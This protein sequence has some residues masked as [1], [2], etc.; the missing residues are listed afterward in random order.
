MKQRLAILWI[1]VI[2]FASA[3]I[4]SGKQQ[5][6]Y[7]NHYTTQHGLP[8]N[9]VYN[10]VQDK[11]GFI[12]VSTRDGIARFDGNN[13][14]KMEMDEDETVL[15]GGSTTMC[16]DEDGAIWF[17]SKNRVCSYDPCTGVTKTIGEFGAMRA[18]S[19]TSDSKGNIWFVAGTL[20][21]YTKET[22]ELKAYPREEY[23]VPSSIVPDASGTLWAV[24]SDGSVY[25]YDS[26]TDHFEETPL[27]DVRRLESTASGK[28]MACTSEDEILVIEPH[29]F[30]IKTILTE[31]ET[32]GWRNILCM[33]ER[34]PGEYWIGTETGI[35]VYV[36][37]RGI[38][39]VI[40]EN[41]LDKHAI[42]ASYV[43]KMFAD[44]DGNIWAGTYYTG[45]NL[46]Q[47]KKDAFQFYYDY[48]DEN[49]LTGNIVRPIKSDGDDVIWFGTED[50]ELNRYNIISHDTQTFDTKDLFYNIQDILPDKGE[51]W[52][53]TYGN[54]LLKYNPETKQITARYMLG[55]GYVIRVFKTSGN[56]ILAG[57]RNGLYRYDEASGKFE[58][59]SSVKPHFIHA[60]FQDHNG[61][62]WIGTLGDGIRV[63]DKDFNLI[64]EIDA[65][66]ENGLSSSHITSI[67]EDSKNRIWTTT[68]GAGVF[69]TSPNTTIEGIKFMNLSKEDGL[70]S[71]VTCSV[72][73][74][75]DGL[76]WISTTR[77]IA[78]FNPETSS[79]TTTF[80]GKSQITG[81]QYTFDSSIITR[82]GTIYMGTTGGMVS[83]SPSI[84]NSIIPD[85]QLF[86]FV[87]RFYMA[88]PVA[89]IGKELGCS[90]STVKREI[91]AIKNGLKKRLESE[92][93]TV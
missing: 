16:I 52:V 36:E 58:P 53:A 39:Y 27:P 30:E 3:G 26:R 20:Y 34:V 83:F 37:G 41:L 81:G 92:G 77:G 74:D 38:T 32:E 11:L 10:I 33:A 82:S 46:W 7:F 51:I 18:N 79:L 72:E 17:C 31:K 86:I 67:F 88:E 89:A 2:M 62:I 23:P 63:M 69:Y 73:E 4:A 64:A 40:Q 60:L 24:T 56:D 50:G 15:S 71:D 47:N 76:I 35:R 59:V 25:R 9:T 78:R 70:S 55:S 75:R 68:E 85:R 45:L 29:S 8:S 90:V 84:L 49:S 19:I 43:M 22:E 91:E 65:S 93:Y 42:S 57:T 61:N 44:K 13:F 12:W 14:V 54:G 5:H 80:F 6:Y 48:K 21:R 28:L 87:S 1:T 66:E